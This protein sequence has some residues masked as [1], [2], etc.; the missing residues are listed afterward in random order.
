MA[1][2]T[3]GLVQ[4]GSATFFSTGPIDVATQGALGP[5]GSVTSSTSI[6]GINVSGTEEVLTAS[7]ASSMCTVSEAGAEGSTTIVDGVLRVSEGTPN[8]GDEVYVGV[9][10]SPIANTTFN[11][12][13][14]STGDTFQYI[15]NE[16]VVN[17]DGSL[18]VYAGH[19]RLL[20]PNAVGEVYWGKSECGVTST[21][22]ATP[23]ISTVASAGGP[24][25]TSI[26]DDATVSGG[27]SPTGTVEFRLYGPDDDICATVIFISS[28]RPLTS[29]GTATSGS[30]TPTAAGTYRW[31]AIYSGDANNVPVSAPCNAPNESVTITAATPDIVTQASAGGP[32]G[33]PVHDVATVSGGVSPTGTVEFDLYGPDN[34][35]C[36][37]GSVFTSTVPLAADGTATSGPFTPTVA[38]TYR[39]RAGY[40]GDANNAS[41][42][43]PCN[44]PNESVTISA[45]VANL[46]VAKECTPATARAGGGIA[47]GDT[48]NCEIKVTN[49]GPSTATDVTLTDDLPPGMT[50]VPGS[51]TSSPSPGGFACTTHPTDPELRCEDPA[52]AVGE[53]NIVAYSATVTDSAGPG[54][55]FTNEAIADASNAEPATARE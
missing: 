36:S 17:P 6:S 44:A 32:V 55:T 38:G 35:D 30:F 53:T 3:S 2:A 8:P 50:I 20:G 22:S 54:Q 12:S 18:T 29:D 51:V 19:L 10:T 27:T 33:T 49:N 31:R 13:T 41:V 15:F 25:G 46:V 45:P 24:V 52:L 1:N 40:S 26:T 43:A 21:I 28:N 48:V 47:P 42:T 37:G 39:W 14:E 23:T 34:D 5:A 11:G 7:S 4:Y 9:P 16:Q